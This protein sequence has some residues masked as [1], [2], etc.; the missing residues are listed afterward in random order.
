LSYTVTEKG[1]VTIPVE[2]RKKLRLKKG[3]KVRF[4]ETEEGALI[5]PSLTF[6]ELRGVIKKEIA[7]E[8][9]K[10]LEAERRQEAKRDEA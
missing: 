3:S 4:V 7:Y 1:T 8:I 10:E 5:I 2:L 9:I 6:E